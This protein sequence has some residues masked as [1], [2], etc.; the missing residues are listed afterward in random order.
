MSSAIPPSRPS[1]PPPPGTGAPAGSS[2]YVSMPSRQRG[3]APQPHEPYTATGW[4]ASRPTTPAP[5]ACTQ[6]V[7]SW[8]RVNGGPHGSCPASKSRIR[9]RSEWQAPEPPTRTTTCPGPGAGSSTSTSTG[10]DFHSF[11]R[12][13]FMA[14]APP[15]VADRHL[16]QRGDLADGCWAD[17]CWS[18][19]GGGTRCGTGGGPGG[20]TERR[21]GSGTVQRG[22]LGPDLG[23]LGH[24]EPGVERLGPQPVPAGRPVPVQVVLRAAD[25]LVRPGLL[26]PVAAG[27][28]DAQRLGV[29]AQCPVGGAE[30]PGGDPEPVAYDR[31]QRRQA[32]VAGDVQSAQLVL[33]R[34]VVAAQLAVR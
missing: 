28:G 14:I 24:L 34:E 25:A 2:Q 18:G 17:G 4:P 11:S 27:A 19:S 1:P 23:D 32:M 22:E 31:L 15:S 7:F 20:G 9:C 6:P 13:A 21:P 30:R 3:Q 16:L 8:P 29:V 12:S 33:V 5:T 26:V 10:S